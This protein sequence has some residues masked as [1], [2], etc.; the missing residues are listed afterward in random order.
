[1]AVNHKCSQALLPLDA[2]SMLSLLIPLLQRQSYISVRSYVSTYV[3]FPYVF[4]LS[5]S[6][7]FMILFCVHCCDSKAVVQTL[8]Q[9]GALETVTVGK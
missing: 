9:Y 8:Q 1:V 2:C 7:L 3:L 5:G 4:P 6:G